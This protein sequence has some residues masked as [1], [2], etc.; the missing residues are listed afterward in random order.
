MWKAIQRFRGLGAEAQ[1]VFGRAVVLFPWVLFSLRTRGFNKTK[2][3]LQA[4]LAQSAPLFGKSNSD[5]EKVQ[6]ISRM[7][8]AA[9]RYGL[10][11]PNCLEESLVLWHCLQREQVSVALRIGVR[12]FAGQ[13]EAHAW[14]EY[15][16]VAL[17]QAEWAHPHYAAF[18][19]EFSNLPGENA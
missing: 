7:V 10:T 3:A 4:R 9:G 15:Q 17:N 11:H 13:F 1:K 16:G 8:K 12:K 2:L 5:G 6:L 14:V 18:E 19:S